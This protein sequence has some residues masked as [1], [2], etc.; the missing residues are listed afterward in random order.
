MH[1]SVKKWGN[2]ASIRIPASIMRST[3]LHIDE[4]VDI[5]EE[6]GRIIIEVIKPDYNLEQ[7]LS[8]ITP[9]NLHAEVNFGEAIG[10][11]IL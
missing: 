5:H 9:E 7:L 8:D 4:V 11:E 10:K 6:N 1:I 2:S 3:N